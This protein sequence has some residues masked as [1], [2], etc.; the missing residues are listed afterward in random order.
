MIILKK[1]VTLYVVLKHVVF[2]INETILSNF[3]SETFWTPRGI[4]PVSLRM[5][6][7]C[8]TIIPRSVHISQ[9]NN[10]YIFINKLEDKRS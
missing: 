2:K 8:A 6:S 4:E 7:E 5:M 1:I 3:P 9:G 10:T